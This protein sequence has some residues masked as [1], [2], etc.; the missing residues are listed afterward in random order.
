VRIVDENGNGVD[1]GSVMVDGPSDEATRGFF[2]SNWVESDAEGRCTVTGCPNSDLRVMAR[3]KGGDYSSADVSHV[4]AGGEEVIVPVTSARHLT[5]WIE[6]TVVDP[7]GHPASARLFAYDLNHRP[8]FATFEAS[9][10]TTGHFKLGPFA[11][12]TF[13][14]QVRADGYP[15]TDLDVGAIAANE[16]KDV[17]ALQLVRGGMLHVDVHSASGAPPEKLEAEGRATRFRDFMQDY[18]S[19]DCDDATVTSRPTAPG[20][21]KI[22]LRASHGA[23]A[24]RTVTI[25]SGETTTLEVTLEPALAVTLKVPLSDDVRKRL[26]S[27]GKTLHARVADRDGNTVASHPLANQDGHF[28]WTVELGVGSYTFEEVDGGDLLGTGK[29]EVAESNRSEATIEIALR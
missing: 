24:I 11:P 23:P 12:G 29:F 20:E 3:F 21:Y 19:L 5:A 7:D 28:E 22:V 17:G 27:T 4:R 6:G 10:S 8:G 9:D 25:R 26:A 16:V 18:M 2:N 15:I 13:R 1:G 14:L